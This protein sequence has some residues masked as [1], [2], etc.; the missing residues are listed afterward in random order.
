M[1][2]TIKLTD[3]CLR[4]KQ[5]KR[6]ADYLSE[7]HGLPYLDG[8][9]FRHEYDGKVPMPMKIEKNG[10]IMWVDRYYI[11]Y[12]LEDGILHYAYNTRYHIIEEHRNWAETARE[13][14]G[15]VQMPK[16]V[17]RIF[18]RCGYEMFL[19]GRTCW[20]E[21]KILEKIFCKSENETK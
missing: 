4:C 16:D 15:A 17:Q 13:R 6:I 14:N 18:Y 10:C 12:A 11:A 21:K 8:T 9:L 1:N 20:I 19:T 2:I 3:E 5:I 7:L